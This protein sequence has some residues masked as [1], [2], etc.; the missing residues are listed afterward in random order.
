M[1]LALAREV[2]DRFEV[3]VLHQV[4]GMTETGGITTVTPADAPL[5]KAV[6]SVG[7]PLPNFE[8]RLRSP[9]TGLE[10]TDGEEG[11]L[12]V[13]SPYNAV[14]YQG[15]SEEEA[16]KYFAPD[17]WYKT[18]DIMARDGSGGFYFRG[19]AKDMIKVKGENVAALEV[20]QVLLSH[21]R[22]A[23]AAVVGLPDP[24]R[25]EAVVAYVETNDECAA[26]ELLAL[27]RRHLAP[28]KLPTAI[29]FRKAWPTTA[30]GKIRKVALVEE[31]QRASETSPVGGDRVSP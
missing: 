5:D 27:C 22:V 18:G 9:A 15:M 26:E 23:Q 2:V 29:Y 20:E 14:G 11:E 21:P 12:W 17:G 30:T 25:G 7:R 8:L 10:V 31:L 24:V 16:A 1:P 19:R 4:Y 3:D 28:F 6:A 13:R